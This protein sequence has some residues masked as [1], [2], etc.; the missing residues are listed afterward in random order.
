V[1]P[2]LPRDF[3]IEG[4]EALKLG[5]FTCD[6]GWYSCPLSEDGCA[7]DRQTECTCAAG[8]LNAKIDALIAQL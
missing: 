1:T 8:A 4:L 5:H 2:G 7:D 3:I 6:A